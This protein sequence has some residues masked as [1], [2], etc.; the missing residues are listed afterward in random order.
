MLIKILIRSSIYGT[1]VGC[2]KG[3]TSTYYSSDT[4]AQF[5][6]RIPTVVVIKVKSRGKRNRTQ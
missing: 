6:D 4:A 1:G 2:Y 5:Y 3:D